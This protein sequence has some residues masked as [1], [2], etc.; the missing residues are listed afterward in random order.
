MSP[1]KRGLPAVTAG[2][3]L[4]T[5]FVAV[6]SIPVAIAADL[7]LSTA[8]TAGWIMTAYGAPSV[9][10]I[11]LVL[12]YRQPLLLTGNIFILIFVASLGTEFEWAE[13]VGASMVAGALVLALSVGGL[14]RRLS[15]WLPPP[16]V[17]GLLAGAVLPF[18]VEAFTLLSDHRFL[19]GG[20]IAAYLVAYRVIGDRLALLPALVAGV[21]IAAITGNL[22]AT[23]RLAFPSPA[24]TWPTFSL[25]AILTT[26]PVFVALIILQA[27]IPSLVFLRAEGYR[28]PERTID[29]T[30]GIGTI[31]GSLL[32][33]MGISLSLPATSLVAGPPA[34]DKGSRF[35]AAH[36]AAG[37]GVL[38]ALLAGL[39]TEL[40][41]IIPRALLVTAVALAVVLVLINALRDVTKGPLRLGPIF[42]FGIALSDLSLLGL[43]PFFWALIGGVAI[44][45]A[46]E[47]EQWK[48]IKS[49]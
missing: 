26:T 6:L 47:A 18:L 10:S 33:P 4:A 5:I 35:W 24:L 48:K 15:E 19:V 36:L 25:P 42:A 41:E 38:I 16:I 39:A 11:I 23:S 22:E 30:S 21:F 2:L 43:G 28:P 20:T 8:Q 12:R 44:S 34:G 32:G 27:N 3:S 13:L 40:T 37:I 49:H 7:E 9:L 45:R 46:V 29:L 14:S 31:L 1:G 17:F